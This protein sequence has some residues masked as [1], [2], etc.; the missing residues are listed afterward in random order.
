MP[1]VEHTQK[2]RLLFQAG[3]SAEVMDLTP[4]TPAFEFIF[5][6]GSSGLTPFEYALSDKSEG[7][8]VTFPLKKGDLNQFFDHLYPSLGDLFEER[9]EIFLTAKIVSIAPAG[10]REIVKALAE[11]AEAG[12]CGGGCGCGCGGH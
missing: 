10:S 12:G 9:D 3:T 4:K 1:K 11:I 8:E 2:I 7:D 6:M 5:G